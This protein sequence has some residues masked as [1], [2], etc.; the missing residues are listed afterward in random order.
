MFGLGFGLT[1]IGGMGSR[2]GFFFAADVLLLLLLLLLL[3]VEGKLKWRARGDD[4]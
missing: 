1:A 2:A 4:G 3:L